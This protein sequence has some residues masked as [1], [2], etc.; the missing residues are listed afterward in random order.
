MVIV[1]VTVINILAG[2]CMAVHR[3]FGYIWSMFT[4]FI[5]FFLWMTLDFLSTS[6][7][8]HRADFGFRS[9]PSAKSLDH[10]GRLWLPWT[11]P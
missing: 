2:R 3:E 1:I 11:S 6:F 9:G 7:C 8:Y 4:L 10:F 5:D